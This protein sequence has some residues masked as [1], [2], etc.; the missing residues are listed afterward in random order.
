MREILAGLGARTL[1]E[2]IGHTELLQQAVV[3]ADAGNMDLLPLL[4]APDTG[5]ARRNVDARNP[6][7]SS[8]PLGDRLTADVLAALQSFEFEGRDLRAERER[9]PARLA[10]YPAVH[11]SYAIRNTDRTVGGKLSGELAQRYGDAGLS[12]DTIVVELRGT[13]GQSFGALLLRGL[14]LRLVGQANDYVGKGLGGGEIVIRPPDEAQYVWHHN[15]ILGNTALYGATGG[16]LYAAG[17]A[18]ERFAVRN[19][20]ARAVVE[21]VGDHGC[22]YMTG[23]V[24]VVLGKTGRNFGAGM[25]GGVAY[26]YD[27]HDMLTA[28]ANQQLVCLR[29]VERAEDQAELKALLERHLDAPPARAPAPSWRTGRTSS[30]SSGGRAGGTGRRAGGRERRRDRRRRSPRGQAVGSAPRLSEAGQD[31]THH[32]VTKTLSPQRHTILTFFRLSSLCVFALGAFVVKEVT[33]P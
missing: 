19:S 30:R 29:R 33:C 16:E 8:S 21:G 18:G 31:S 20:G 2:I 9:L 25:T 5:Y 17:R 32:K 1:D 23:G 24:V 22:E 14:S 7:R 10:Q 27:K 11:L 28:R 12:P 26:V 6:L 3:G 15:V 13:A 4:W